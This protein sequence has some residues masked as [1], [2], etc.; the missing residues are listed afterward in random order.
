MTEITLSLT[1]NEGIE[2]SERISRT[3]P[4]ISGY[5]NLDYLEE[6]LH[7]WNEELE[8]D[9]DYFWD[10]GITYSGF[11][12]LFNKQS[13][14]ENER[15]LAA[16]LAI[17]SNHL[18]CLNYKIIIDPKRRTVSFEIEPGKIKIR[19]EFAS[20]LKLEPIQKLLE[21]R[22]NKIKDI[23]ISINDAIKRYSDAND[24]NYI[25]DPKIYYPVYNPDQQCL[26]FEQR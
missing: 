7:K 18:G 9:K 20:E 25:Q 12:F 15:F 26:K 22:L 10:E 21:E 6:E 13:N 14:D 23:N 19:T 17:S 16:M 24:L 1:S 11:M 8:F 4:R 5:H 2:D 3:I